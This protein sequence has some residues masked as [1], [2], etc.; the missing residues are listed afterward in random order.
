MELRVLRYFLAV[1]REE[2]I[3]RAAETLHV[4]QP[5]LS[6]QIAQ[7]EEELGTPLFVRGRHLTLTDAGVLLRRRAEEVVQLMDKIES[8]FQGQENVAGTIT[9]GSGG[10]GSAA[11]LAQ[12]M[13]AFRREHPK[14]TYSI[15]T[16]NAD[17]IKEYLDRGLIDFGLLL[18]PIDVSKY[19]YLRLDARERWGILMPAG[20]PLAVKDHITREDLQDVPLITTNRLALRRELSNWFGTE[21]GQLNLFA[22]YNIITNVAT[23]VADGAA[24]ALTIEGAVGLFDPA[25]IVFRP[26]FPEL[27]MT[28]VLAWK[29]FSPVFGAAGK[30][31]EHFKHIHSEYI[32]I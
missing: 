21:L 24:C 29:K 23:L 27:T 19:D 4:A 7:L 3:S 25:K 26:L 28:S 22:T 18:E 1:V 20:H 15:Y 30:F 13:E 8:E 5:S 14:I 9:F 32:N 6:R 17:S 11:I 16:N 2:N 31:L 12:A 10:Q